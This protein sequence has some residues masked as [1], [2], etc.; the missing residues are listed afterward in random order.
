MLGDV[1]SKA[2]SNNLKDGLMITNRIFPKIVVPFAKIAPVSLVRKRQAFRF[3]FL[4]HTCEGLGI[5]NCS[6]GS[7]ASDNF[8]GPLRE[9]RDDPTVP[10][11]KHLKGKTM[12]ANYQLPFCTQFREVLRPP[13]GEAIGQRVNKL[14]G[15]LLLECGCDLRV[16]S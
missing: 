16:H 15:L 4:N 5:R 7:E 13:V 11:T 8:L 6:N 3:R 14:V 2:A 1:L 10:A 12:A 9:I